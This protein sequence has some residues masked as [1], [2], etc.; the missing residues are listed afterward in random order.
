MNNE[1]QASLE[2][3]YEIIRSTLALFD[4]LIVFENKKLDAIAANDI[5]LLDQHM[6]EEQAYLLKMR[7]LDA[8][9]EKV[10]KELGFAGLTFREIIEK[11]EAADKAALLP[12]FEELNEKSAELKAGIRSTKRYLDLHV[13]SIA[14]LLE[15]LEAGG[16]TYDQSGEKTNQADPPKRFIPTKA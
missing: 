3:L 9:R 12:L 2:P 14:A 16:A 5:L 4:D 15:K 8:K 7:G 13:N 6:N 11:A 1:K 10:Q